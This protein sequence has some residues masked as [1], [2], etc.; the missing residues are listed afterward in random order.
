MR[1]ATNKAK[2]VSNSVVCKAV[3]KLKCNYMPFLMPFDEKKIIIEKNVLDFYYMWSRRRRQCG[4]RRMVNLIMEFFCIILQYLSMTLLPVEQLAYFLFYLFF[5][6]VCFFLPL[7]FRRR[8]FREIIWSTRK[9]LCWLCE[10]KRA[11]IVTSRSI[12]DRKCR[13]YA[14]NECA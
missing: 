11:T 4:V 13:N 6:F 8:L 1:Q 5:L 2:S 9:A 10:N 14:H 12:F 7:F 3:Y